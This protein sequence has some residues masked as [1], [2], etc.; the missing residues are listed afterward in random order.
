MY[1]IQGDNAYIGTI[2]ARNVDKLPVGNWII[3]YDPMKAIYFLKKE[4]DFKLPEKIYGDP[5][6]FVK[7]VLNTYNSKDSNLGVL[8]KGLKGTGKT[9]TST[10][11]AKRS[12]LPVISLVDP[13]SGT[14]FL[15][16]ISSIRE[17]AVIIIDEFEKLYPQDLQQHLLTLLDGVIQGNKLF[18]LTANEER[19]HDALLNRPGRI[20]YCRTYSGLEDSVI[21]DVI[22]DLLHN[23][24][25]KQVLLESISVMGNINLDSLITWIKEMNMYKEG[26]KEAIKWLNVSPETNTTYTS[27]VKFPDTMEHHRGGYGGE[28]DLVCSD[29]FSGINLDGYLSKQK[30]KTS[31]DDNTKSSFEALGGSVYIDEFIPREN[32]EIKG[33][34][35]SKLR[36]VIVSENHIY[37]GLEFILEKKSSYTFV[38]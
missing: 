19:F 20:H 18:I 5:S 21:E 17:K 34:G 4:V 23:K 35:N 8:L 24:S 12:G 10:M 7:R 38:L 15:T 29:P 36:V 32:L 3:S 31:E 22:D 37:D 13:F 14:D 1:H 2:N 16:F 30:K 26:P 33:V 6:I 27:T 9:L 25:H 11:I 28:L